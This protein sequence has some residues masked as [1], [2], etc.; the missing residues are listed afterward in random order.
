MHFFFGLHTIR[1][2]FRGRVPTY[3]FYHVSVRTPFQKKTVAS[4]EPLH[5]LQRS[6][7]CRVLLGW[8]EERCRSSSKRLDRLSNLLSCAARIRRLRMRERNRGRERTFA[9]L[10]KHRKWQCVVQAMMI[11]VVKKMIVCKLCVNCVRCA[12]DGQDHHPRG[13]VIRHYRHGQV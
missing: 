2:V 8:G 6:L 7:D 10:Q 1:W 11:R 3:S 5:F 4:F 13:R 12:A 9:P